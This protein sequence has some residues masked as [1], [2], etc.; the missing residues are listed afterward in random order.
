MGE[1]HLKV[2]NMVLIGCAI[3]LLTSC[4][5]SHY[6]LAVPSP[7][8]NT[9]QTPSKI[10]ETDT[11]TPSSPTAKSE[12][13]ATD[14][15]PPASNHSPSKRVGTPVDSQ[16]FASVPFEK[17]GNSQF[18][19]TSDDRSG[20]AQLHFYIDG[21]KGEFE[22]PYEPTEPDAYYEM[23]AVSFKDVN[24]DNLKDILIIADYTTG[25]GYMGAIPVSQ[26]IIFTQTETGFVEATSLEEHIEDASAYRELNMAAVLELL[27]TDPADGPAHAWAKLPV[28]EYELTDS[29]PN[30]GSNITIEKTDGR[31]M[32]FS[33]DAFHV[34]GGEE[35]LKK[36][37]VH[38]GN[39]DSATTALAD[40]EMIYREGDYELSITLITPDTFYMQDNGSPQFGANVSVNG[41]YRLKKKG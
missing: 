17:V 19:T 32:T 3:V 29:T 26:A 16:S 22:L 28:G 9:S 30:M 5:E 34:T 7:T 4:R 11:N 27:G 41:T 38:T 8:A 10:P 25:F 24:A 33:L 13:P 1:N 20:K 12:L 36:G 37:S 23:K 39:L 14:H 15:T 2:T 21:P 31:S 18:I 35:G 6:E 40:K